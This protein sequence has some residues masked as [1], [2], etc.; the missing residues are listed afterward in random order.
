MDGGLSNGAID[1]L[2]GHVAESIVADHLRSYGHEVLFPATSNQ[3]GYDLVVD[4]HAYNVKDLAQ[5]SETSHH[6]E[7]ETRIYRLFV[8]YDI[9]DMP[10]YVFTSHLS[11]R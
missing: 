7:R 8:N 9:A 2:Q 10:H 11:H 3:Q 1:C 4:G 6:F 5:F